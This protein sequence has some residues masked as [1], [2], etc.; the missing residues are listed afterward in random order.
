MN[1]FNQKI[2][3]GLYEFCLNADKQTIQETLD[4]LD[5]RED[6]IA[7]S[8]L[9]KRIQFSAKASLNKQKDEYLLN[10][11][12]SQ[13]QAAIEK[14]TEKPLYMLQNL[15]TTGDLGVQ[16]RNLA[17]LTEEDLKDLIRDKNLLDLL[18]K[19]NDESQNKD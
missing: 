6:S 16:F 9:I 10:L 12:V 14:N 11:V 7:M 2:E 4:S 8:N 1:K 17:S 18:E 13:F 3:A 5:D 15:I 19:L